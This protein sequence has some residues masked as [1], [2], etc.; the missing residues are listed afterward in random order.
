MCVTLT[1]CKNPTM[2]IEDT[3]DVLADILTFE[4]YLSTD[5]CFFAVTLA[6]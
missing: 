3:I 2:N 6:S 4:P 5:V 1:V